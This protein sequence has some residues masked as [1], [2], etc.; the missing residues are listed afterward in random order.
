MHST[1]RHGPRRRVV[2]GAVGKEACIT[3]AT[4]SAVSPVGAL[5]AALSACATPVR[6]RCASAYR[7]G[8]EL[9]DA[10]AACRRLADHGLRATIGYAAKAREPH[11]AVAGAY[12]AA[13]DALAEERFDAY[14][15]VKLPAVGLDAGRFD[16]L[17]A[18]AARCG[19][20]LH[21]DAVAPDAAEATWQLLAGADGAAALGT[22]L[23]GRW[24]RSPDDAGR[25]A[26]LGLAVRVV[27]GQWGDPSGTDADPATGFLDV[28]DRLLGH[29]GVVGVATHDE[30]L[31]EEALR[32]LA[33]A[34][35]PC[36]AELFLGLPFRGPARVARRLGVPLRVYVPYGDAGAPYGRGV[37]AT[38]PAAAAWIAQD[39][40]F[41]K[42]K[43]WRS[44]GP[45]TPP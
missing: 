38:R 22:T 14:V 44:I 12:A 42:E 9:G 24:H 29:H 27:K 6:R 20:R 10:L 40:L 31:L 15:S 30:P 16:M 21:V 41:G 23:A 28:V 19:R 32:R 18:A 5:R 1:R 7:A 43:T 3:S 35:T 13:L 39:L 26:E 45:S 4:T 2:S 34:G 11:D 37:L 17:V 36:E 33:G 8:P 25:A